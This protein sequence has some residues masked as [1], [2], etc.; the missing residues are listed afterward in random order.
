MHFVIKNEPSNFQRMMNEIFTKELSEEWLI[1]YI[2]DII[3]YS[4]TWEEHTYRMSRALSKIQNI[5]KKT[6]A[7]CTP[8]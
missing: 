2:D 4:K 8:P 7:V 5:R 3:V 6:V 1:I